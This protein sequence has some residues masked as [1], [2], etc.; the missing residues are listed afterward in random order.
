MKRAD[1]S[2]HPLE[3]HQKPKLCPE[4][5]AMAETADFTERDISGDART[6]LIASATIN[7][8]HSERCRTKGANSRHDRRARRK[9]AQNRFDRCARKSEAAAQAVLKANNGAWIR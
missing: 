5:I 8:A 4:L 3:C 1:L 9:K 2:A 6:G 7:N